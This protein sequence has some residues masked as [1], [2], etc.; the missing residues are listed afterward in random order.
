MGIKNI[1]KKVGATIVDVTGKAAKAAI[2]AGLTS[3]MIDGLDKVAKNYKQKK[4]VA[5]EQQE[6]LKTTVETV[7]V[8]AIEVE[9]EV[10]TEEIPETTE[11]QAEPEPEVEEPVKETKK[12][13]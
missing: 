13:K 4:L 5:A 9:A 6:M 12:K 2:V 11:E 8:E 7:E 1:A 10:P 3:V